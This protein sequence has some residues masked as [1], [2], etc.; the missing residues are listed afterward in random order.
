VE[1]VILEGGGVFEENVRLFEDVPESR[2]LW[3]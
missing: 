2:S 3:D 1:R